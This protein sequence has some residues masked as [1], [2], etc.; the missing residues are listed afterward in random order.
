MR[1]LGISA[2]YHDAAAV[3][4]VDGIPVAGAHEERFTRRKHD[5]GFPRH[6]VAYCLEAGRLTIDEVDHVVFYEKPFLKFERL[7]TTVVAMAPANF[8]QYLTA[9]PVWMRE[10]LWL[11]SL[12]RKELG[13]DGSLLFS[14]HHR[15]H[16]ASAFFASGFEEAS[17]L[18]V[19]GVGEWETG[20]RGWGKGHEL[21]LT[22]ATHF[23]HSLGLLYSAFTGYLGF[24]VNSGEYKVMGLAP[25]GRPRYADLIRR[26]LVEWGDDGGLRLNMRHFA[27]ASGLRMI[28]RSFEELFGLPTREPE[29]ALTQEHKDIAASIQEVT[30]QIMVAAA[31]D[32]VRTTGL[33]D[34]CLA[35][36]VALNCV[37]NEQILRHANVRR[38]F[39]QPAAGD[40]GG[41]LGAALDVWHSVLKQP[42]SWHQDGVAW[43]PEYSDDA[44]GALLAEH[45]IP[46]E[47]LSQDELIARTVDAL[48]RQEVVG[49]FHGRMEWGPRALGSRSI[50]ADPR[51]PDN[52]KRVNLKIKFRESFRPFAPAVTEEAFGDWFDG[53]PDSYMLVTCRVRPGRVPLPSVTHVDGSARTQS[54]SRRHSPVFHRLITAFGER[55]GVPVLINTSFNVRGEPIVCSP[56]D[57]LRCFYATN[58]DSLAMGHYFVS[59]TSAPALDPGRFGATSIQLD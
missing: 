18:T 59:K 13:F 27:F 33:P 15:S 57:A 24:R 20:T 47:R 21:V 32:I 6:A 38:L 14:G 31:R 43:G 8:R 48:E 35:G 37:A 26:E 25:Y 58:I 45:G 11:P 34:L 28:R 1:I 19:D 30:N 23:P 3:L 53:V 10:K 50:L 29:S 55:T 9:M 44:I 22:E 5:P 42:R 4:L 51:N 2:Y 54:V 40:A 46:S 49:W 17:I 39:V 12:I 52:Q 41:A 36:G 7:L 16:A 56:R